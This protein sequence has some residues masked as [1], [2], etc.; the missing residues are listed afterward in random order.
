MAENR[1]RQNSEFGV[2]IGEYH[3]IPVLSVKGEVTVDSEERLKEVSCQFEKAP[4]IIVNLTK[5]EYFG[6]TGVRW[7]LR[8]RENHSGIVFFIL[9]SDGVKRI[10]KATGLLPFF[11]VFD[12]YETACNALDAIVEATTK[13]S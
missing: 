6:S 10:L 13:K 4:L 12:D 3:G 1:E 7:L 8:W 11:P 9:V 2:E 5:V